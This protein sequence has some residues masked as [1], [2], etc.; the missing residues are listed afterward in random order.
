MKPGLSGRMG[1][2]SYCSPLM[3]GCAVCRRRARRTLG[4]LCICLYS[5]SFFSSFLFSSFHSFLNVWL[6]S[7]ISFY[8]F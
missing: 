7:L 2:V 6:G 1:F 8:V 3:R 4:I 5:F